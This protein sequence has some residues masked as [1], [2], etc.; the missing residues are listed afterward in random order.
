MMVTK[1]VLWIVLMLQ[2][3]RPSENLLNDEIAKGKDFTFYVGTYTRNTESKGIYKYQLLA[4]GSLKNLGLVAESEN[5]SFIAK[6]ADG[7]YLMAANENREGT[8][9]SFSIN[10]DEVK[11]L[12]K[13]PTNGASPCFVT[14]DPSGYVLATNYN[15]GS[16][17]LYKLSSV[18]LLEGPLD[19]LQHEGKGTEPR[20]AGP[21]AHSAWFDPSTKDA[22]I[23]VDLG[24]ND[25]WFSKLD[26]T[27][28]KLIPMSPNKL[29][30]PAGSGPRH[31]A[32]HPTGG[33][34]YVINEL[35]STISIVKK[36]STGTYEVAGT[37]TTLPEGFTG[38]GQT[39]DIRVSADGKFLYGS[40]R[41]NNTIVIYQINK[42]DGS[43]TLVGHESV[44][45]DGPRNF[46]LSPDG[47]FL[48]VA[49]QRS[50]NIVSFK[51]DA[52]IGTLKF[53]SEIPAPAPVCLLF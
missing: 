2:L 28:N 46:S 13:K 14:I 39:A 36:N 47:E 53:V 50:N 10:G 9:S 48:L 35:S 33:W 30:M 15:S 22:V 31:L 1:G 37:Y 7:K 5:P 19:I 44:K 25:L 38:A 21:H 17:A 18:G 16:V 11:P 42:K 45:G 20:Q 29:A 8:I 3:V 24:T 4:D 40:N 43:L 34:L 23:S 27:N 12:D 41:G 32:F 51:R 52:K 6:S 26:R 49:N